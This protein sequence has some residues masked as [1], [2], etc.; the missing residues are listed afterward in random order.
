[1]INQFDK[2]FEDFNEHVTDW[3]QSCELVPQAYINI[4]A[5]SIYINII[6]NSSYTEGHVKIKVSCHHFEEKKYIRI[7]RDV[8][9]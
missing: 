2:I 5:L 3:Y 6:T 9:I 4:E 8:R 1:M 7:K